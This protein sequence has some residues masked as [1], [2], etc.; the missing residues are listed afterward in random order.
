MAARNAVA[1]TRDYAKALGFSDVKVLL[2]ADRGDSAQNYVGMTTRA[3]GSAGGRDNQEDMQF[4]PN[5]VE[6]SASASCEFQVI[7]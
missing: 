6:L 3:R 2:L 7:F 5:D 1:K 4:T